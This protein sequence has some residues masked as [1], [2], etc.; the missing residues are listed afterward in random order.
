MIFEKKALRS[1]IWVVLMFLSFLVLITPVLGTENV[2]KPMV[3][4]PFD[5]YTFVGNLALDVGF[6]NSGRDA[7][8]SASQIKGHP[9]LIGDGLKFRGDEH[10]DWGNWTNTLYDARYW[11]IWF[12][13]NSSEPGV[14]FTF[15]GFGSTN[16]QLAWEYRSGDIMRVYVRDNEAGSTSYQDWTPAQWGVTGGWNH[17]FVNDSIDGDNKV[18]VYINGVL[19]WTSN[20]DIPKYNTSDPTQ[21][22]MIFG[23]A[24]IPSSTWGDCYVDEFSVYNRTLSSADIQTIYNGGLGFT[25]ISYTPPFEG[26]GTELYPY[27][28]DN[29]SQMQNITDVNDSAYYYL[30][31]DI[32]CRD[33]VPTNGYYIVGGFSGDFDGGQHIISNVLINYTSSAPGI[34]TGF[35]KSSGFGANVHDV[36]FDNITITCVAPW[37]TRCETNGVLFGYADENMT[38]SRV[39]IR[40]SFVEGHH[41]LGMIGGKMPNAPGDMSGNLTDVYII[42]SRVKSHIT[43]IDY[44]TIGIVQMTSRIAS[45]TNVYSDIDFESLLGAG[46]CFFADQSSSVNTGTYFNNETC[47]ESIYDSYGAVDGLTDLEFTNPDLTL[48]DTYTSDVWYHENG[49]YPIF[50]WEYE[51]RPRPD[52]YS[53]NASVYS[54]IND[55]TISFIVSDTDDLIASCSIY[56]NGEINSTNSSIN[57]GNLTYLSISNVPDGSHSYRIG[58]IGEENISYSP[59][60]DYFVDTVAPVFYIGYPNLTNDSIANYTFTLFGNASDLNI[61][62]ALVILKYPNGTDL[63]ESNTTEWSQFFNLTGYEIGQYY[64]EY[65][66]NDTFTNEAMLNTTLTISDDVLPLCFGLDDSTIYYDSTYN[67]NVNCVDERLFF[68]FNI[69]CSGGTVFSYSEIGIN[70]STYNFGESTVITNV[71]SCIYRYCDGHTKRDLEKSWYIRPKNKTIEFEADGK[72]NKL[73]TVDDSTFTY[74]KKKDRVIF[75]ISFKK[76]SLMGYTLFYETSENAYYYPDDEYRGWIVDYDSQTWF[77]LNEIDGGT[78][79]KVIPYNKTTWEIIILPIDI[80]KKD[81][82][83]NSVGELNCVDGTQNINVTAKPAIDSAFGI[84]PTMSCPLDEDLSFQFGYAFL[85]IMLMGILWVNEAYLKVP[86]INFLVGFSF[87]GITV[88][89]YMCSKLI[90]MPFTV[91]GLIL[92][93]SEFDRFFGK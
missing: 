86:L 10:Q 17:F 28:I 48:W 1:M 69:T 47:N 4:L 81:F 6:E 60:Y 66:A 62:S 93:L 59:Y 91:F 27:L 3:Y 74:Q 26:G 85:I 71:S 88:P 65:Y 44:N 32:D 8:F 58:C 40:N 7:L 18:D 77:D 82:S 25:P 31:K 21:R 41:Y 80:N 14:I 29:C 24:S 19:K 43:H 16:S 9:G 23:S 73:K 46:S 50:M 72:I 20:Q 68:S 5:N 36:L 67:W 63:W 35:F 70:S 45:N 15:N 54:N 42:N 83:F 33:V 75:N 89:I 52:I 2:T 49:S 57:V 78:D 76:K 90:G 61:D 56:L 39:G 87:I 92:I 51:R 11:S 13:Y 12:K 64:I 38:V 84:F 34:N 79:I 30:T 55:L 37:D 53:P 22:G